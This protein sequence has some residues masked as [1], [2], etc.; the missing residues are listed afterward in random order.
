MLD[1]V[2]FAIILLFSHVPIAAQDPI[3]EVQDAKIS[4]GFKESFRSYVSG[5]IADGEW[6][7]SGDVSYA[8]PIFEFSHGR[9]ILGEKLHNGEVRF[10][11]GIQFTGH[12]GILNTS[13]AQPVLRIDGPGQATLFLNV[14]GQTMDNHEVDRERVA[15]AVALWESSS[16]VFSSDGLE[17]SVKDAVVHLTDS[18]AKSFGTYGPR[19][20]MDPMSFFIRV[21]D[22]CDVEIP[23]QGSLLA[24]YVTACF[25]A[26]AI[27]SLAIRED[28]KLPEPAQS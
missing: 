24:G 2:V 9:G 8:T 25:F 26:V 27:L 21:G 10:D 6:A 12:S 16:Q 3:C 1:A 5:S 15:F 13:L 18:G 17:W 11:G 4:W 7:T 14:R 28:R 20:P 22:G 23:L 19:E